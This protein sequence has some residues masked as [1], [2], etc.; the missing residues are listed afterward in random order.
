MSDIQAGTVI[1]GRYQMETRLDSGGNAEVWR[2]TDQ[3]L[4]REVAVK[5]LVTP[6]GGDPAFI[7]A[8]RTEA[9]IEAGLKHPS[10]VE[11]FDWGHDGAMNYI[12]MELLSGYTVQQHLDGEGPSAAP[13]VLGV[14]RQVASALAYAHQ[15][16]VAHGT[17]SPRTIMVRS[18]GHATVIG[19][20]LWC[21]GTCEAPPTPDT[22]TYMLGGVLYEMLSGASPF[23]PRPI[24]VAEDQP[25]PQPVHKLAPDTPHEL[26]RVVMKAISP[27]AA[28]RYT[29]AAELEA[30]LDAI[31]KPKSRAWLWILLAV[32]AV[33]LAAAGTWFFVSQQK[34]VVPDVTGKTQAE[35]NT[36]LSS[37]GLK[38][39]VTGNQP[40]ASV[41]AGSVTSETPAPG[42]SI[43]KGGQVSV[44]VSTGKPQVAVPSL[45]GV[46]L[47]TA[48]T[49]LDSAGLVVGTVD[50]QNSDNIQT[51]AVISSTPA[52][53]TQ[54]AVGTSINLVVSSG[55]K[56]VTVPDVRGQSQANATAALN[57]AGLKV[58][59]GTAYSSS[60]PAGDVISQ[61]PAQGTV[62][63]VGSTVTIQVSQGSTPVKVP[64]IVGN[65]GV[66]VSDA[67]Q[68]LINLGLVP[69]LSTESA[70]DTWTVTAQDPAAGTLVAPGSTVNITASVNP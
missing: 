21:R 38:M 27:D 70:T 33:I 25:W 10:I 51:D 31:A 6:P 61:S 13:I 54:V 40:S 3:E 12:V 11:V 58:Q 52:A 16:G 41:A 67:K 53:G 17:V 68:T 29:S 35:A 18:D 32:L 48:T 9:Q 44:T 49:Q 47:A 55:K 64:D 69:N 62:V 59:T 65:G 5:V 2:A 23:G 24:S 63:G 7:E 37:V 14:G 36:A 56:T 50:H 8:F 45:V 26:D 22:D 60:Q 66:A 42:Q 20:G 43:R 28:Q 46:P 57:N 4:Q 1:A 19:F 30:D 39:V 34:V 15:V